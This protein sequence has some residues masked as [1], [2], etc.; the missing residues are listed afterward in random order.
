MCVSKD[1]HMVLGN[2]SGGKSPGKTHS[3]FSV[4]VIHLELLFR[5]EAPNF[6]NLCWHVSWYW[7]WTELN[8][9]S[10]LHYVHFDL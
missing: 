8:L 7:N 3:Y 9:L 10:L 1:E 5:D 6:F 2:R 4:V